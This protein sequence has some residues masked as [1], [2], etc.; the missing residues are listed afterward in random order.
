MYKQVSTNA[1]LQIGKGE[2]TG[3][4]SLRRRRSPWTVQ[5]KKKNKNKKK[6]NKK[7]NKKKKKKKKKKKE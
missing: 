5:K 4:N 7:K 1:I 3:R 2:L 6:K